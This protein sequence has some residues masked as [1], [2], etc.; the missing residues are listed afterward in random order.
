MAAKTGPFY[1]HVKRPTPSMTL[2]AKNIYLV[3][4][5]LANY[6]R[7]WLSLAFLASIIIA[8]G[9]LIP[10]QGTHSLPHQDKLVH[11]ITYMGLAGLFT[12][13]LTAQICAK[14]A[15]AIWTG[16]SAFGIIIELL[17]ANLGTGREGSIL[18][19]LANGAGAAIGITIAVSILRGLKIRSN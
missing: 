12:A 15:V 4:Y 16:V 6:K 17:Q 18:D 10:T 1:N 5:R 3:L 11:L 14:H 13:G 19:A 9:S 2:N 7:I 8:V